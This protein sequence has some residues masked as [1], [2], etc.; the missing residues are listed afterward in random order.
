MLKSSRQGTAASQNGF[1]QTRRLLHPHVLRRFQ[2]SVMSYDRE[3]STIKTRAAG[4][5]KE[6]I[7]QS[8]DIGHLGM[9]DP[10]ARMI[11]TSGRQAGQEGCE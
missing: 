4:S 8:L 2:F 9:V 10:Q 5:L 3:T 7:G 11:G 6:G 1:H